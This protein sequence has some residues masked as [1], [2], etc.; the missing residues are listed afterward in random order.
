[1]YERT[2]KQRVLI[3]KTRTGVF[4][5]FLSPVKR[6]THAN[7]IISITPAKISGRISAP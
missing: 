7:E 6:P 4:E 1:M 5:G 3:R 2:V